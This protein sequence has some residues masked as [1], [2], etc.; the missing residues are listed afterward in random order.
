MSET[1]SIAWCDSTWNPWEGCSKISPGCDSCYAEARNQRFHG[2]VNWGPG[3][4]RRLTSSANWKKPLAWNA[5]AA[6]T[7]QPWRVFCASLADVFDNEV[8]AAWRWALFRL[9]RETPHLTWMLLTKRIGNAIGMLD[10]A[11]DAVFDEFVGAGAWQARGPWPNVWIGATV[12]N[13]EEADR[14]IPK[15]LRVPA[16]VRFLSIEPMIEPIDLALACSNLRWTDLDGVEC[17]GVTRLLDW[18]IVGGESDQPGHRARPFVC[19]WGKDIVR[20]CKAAG[21]PVFV[22]QIGDNAT[23]REGEPHP[24]TARAGADPSEWPEDLRVREFPR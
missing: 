3:A 21:V 13:Q 14:D 5:K 11:A 10:E 18:V 6:K 4:P 19:G 8:P 9:I 12:V 15:L 1:T 20:Q 16:A 22:K 17:C 2:G 24:T 23:N 7:G